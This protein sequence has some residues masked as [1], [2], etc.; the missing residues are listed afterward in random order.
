MKLC[1]Y[2]KISLGHCHLTITDPVMIS[3]PPTWHCGAH[4]Q[5]ACLVLLTQAAMYALQSHMMIRA[6]LA[7]QQYFNVAAQISPNNSFKPTPLRGA[8]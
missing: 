2:A 4:L 8:A 5:R 7:A 1:N 6:M 3:K